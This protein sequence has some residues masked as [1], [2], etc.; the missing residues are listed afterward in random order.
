MLNRNGA[1]K[2]GPLRVFSPSMVAKHQKMEGG[3]FS[4]IFYAKKVNAEQTERG[5]L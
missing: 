1:L 2:G 4:E 5:T 3:P